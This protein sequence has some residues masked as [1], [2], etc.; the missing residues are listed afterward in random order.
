MLKEPQMENGAPENEEPMTVSWL[1]KNWGLQLR[2]ILSTEEMK[3][4]RSY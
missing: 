3:T 1:T 2:G 4:T